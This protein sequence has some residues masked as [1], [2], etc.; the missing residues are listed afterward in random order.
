[1]PASENLHNGGRVASD[2]IF[3]RLRFGVARSRGSFAEM[4]RGVMPT[5]VLLVEP[6]WIA[7]VWCAMRQA[8]SPRC[9]HFEMLETLE[10]LASPYGLIGRAVLEMMGQNVG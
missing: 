9:D 6:Q 3:S 5:A 7:P 1:M 8:R 4:P 2:R 10:T